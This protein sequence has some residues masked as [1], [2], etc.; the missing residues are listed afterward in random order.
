MLP[1]SHI[2]ITLWILVIN[3]SMDPSIVNSDSNEPS[4]GH[5]MSVDKQLIL[6]VFI[7]V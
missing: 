5:A 7:L 2:P 3:S 6:F 4:S 1:E